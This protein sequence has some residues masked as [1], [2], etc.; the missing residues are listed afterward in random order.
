MTGR[1]VRFT[2]DGLRVVAAC[3]V[4]GEELAADCGPDSAQLQWDKVIAS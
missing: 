4:V 3:G 1:W 2:T